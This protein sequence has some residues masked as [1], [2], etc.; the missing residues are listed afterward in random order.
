MSGGAAS[1]DEAAREAALA[2]HDSIGLGCGW[3]GYRYPCPCCDAFMAGWL[4]RD[5]PA[6]VGIENY[7]FAYRV[8]RD[9]FLWRDATERA[10]D[11]RA[12]VGEVTG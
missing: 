8:G 6:F 9:A 4:G 3:R 1:R 11:A 2:Y 12:S 10:A 7:S 5:M